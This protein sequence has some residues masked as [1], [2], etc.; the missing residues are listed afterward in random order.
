MGNARSDRKILVRGKFLQ[1]VND[2]GWEY[3]ER[4]NASGVVAIIAVTHEPLAIE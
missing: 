1:L 3:V 4:I 2:R